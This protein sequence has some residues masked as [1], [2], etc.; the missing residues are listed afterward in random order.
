MGM[1]ASQARLLS[2]TARMTDIEGKAQNI[3]AQKITLATQ[4]DELYER[5]CSALDATKI[6]VAFFDDDKSNYMLDAN[7]DTVCNY[8]ENRYRNYMLQ[9]NRS[10]LAIVS[11]KVAEYYNEYANDRY[12]FAWAM[13]GHEQFDYENHGDLRGSALFVG[14]F[15]NKQRS[16]TANEGGYLE[17]ENLIDEKYRDGNVLFMTQAEIEA[18]EKLAGSDPILEDLFNQ[19]NEL[20]EDG[21]A[22]DGEKQVAL[23]AFRKQ[24]YTH[25]TELFDAHN[26]NRQ[27]GGD[28]TIEQAFPGRDW[29]DVS[30]EFNY[31]LNLW[32]FINAS[33]GCQVIEPQYEKGEESYAWFNNSVTAGLI[34]IHEC[35]DENE[36]TWKETSVATSTNKG[37]LKEVQDDTDLKKAEAEYEHELDVINRKDKKFDTELSKLETE[38]N[39]ISK[40]MESIEEVVKKN[41]ERSFGIFS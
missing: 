14:Y 15:N 17:Y 3:Q 36:G 5:Y 41:V 29:N 37:Y 23:D 30:R 20:K 33:G 2:L 13:I 24:L 18:Y 9:D 26:M 10:G 40:Q 34:S 28:G 35:V 38:R 7:F 39:A 6:Q 31:Y 1:A 19:L 32:D 16:Q 4:K 27:D 21:D 8:S 22:T 11:P 12:A 25:K